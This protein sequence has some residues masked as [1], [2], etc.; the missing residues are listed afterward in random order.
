M[1]TRNRLNSQGHDE[2]CYLPKKWFNPK[3]GKDE[4]YPIVNSF[5]A[6]KGDI[7]ENENGN[8]ESLSWLP[9]I[10]FK[11]GNIKKEE[12]DTADSF[13]KILIQAMRVLKVSNIKGQLFDK[14]PA[15]SPNVETDIYLEIVRGLPREQLIKLIWLVTWNTPCKSV[16]LPNEDMKLI[17]HGLYNTQNIIDK[18]KERRRMQESSTE[19]V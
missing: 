9:R 3:T 11:Q 18:S 1:M 17:V 5:R 4:T 15:T 19:Q 6:A 8:L 13:T 10:L 12:F 14:L 7:I 2:S 16:A